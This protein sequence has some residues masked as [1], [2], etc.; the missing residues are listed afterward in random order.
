MDSCK[1]IIIRIVDIFLHFFFILN[2]IRIVFDNFS[3]K[4]KIDPPL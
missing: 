2:V 1:S 3:I 4:N